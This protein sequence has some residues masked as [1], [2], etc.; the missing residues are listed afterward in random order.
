M[1]LGGESP[2]QPVEVLTNPEAPQTICA[3][4]FTGLYEIGTTATPF[5]R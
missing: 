2:S 4:G 3:Q 5:H 1:E